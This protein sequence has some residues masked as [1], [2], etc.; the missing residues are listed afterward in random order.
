MLGTNRLV[1]NKQIIRFVH[2]KLFLNLQTKICQ[3]RT[4]SI[5]K[6][7]LKHKYD[8]THSKIPSRLRPSIFTLL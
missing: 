6:K 2:Q 3:F 7:L 8:D 5:S 4:R 1:E